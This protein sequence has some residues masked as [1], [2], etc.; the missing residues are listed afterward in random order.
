[1]KIKVCGIRTKSNLTFL[2]HE[3]ADFVGFIFYS[4]SSRNFPD[5]DLKPGD[6]IAYNKQK[7]GVFVDESIE[8]IENTVKTYALDYIQLHGNESP[9]YCK[10]LKKKGYKLFKAF[11]VMNELPDDLK[12]YE[13]YVDYFLFDT[14]GQY[15]GGNGVQFDWSLLEQYGLSNPFILS[16]GIGLDDIASLKELKHPKLFAVDVNS[17]FEVAP[18]YKNEEELKEFIKELKE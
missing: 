10:T 1:M 5:G 3:A 7:V 13:A 4:K 2:T 8:A 16:G 18:G 9:A 14:K 11:S 6:L 17:R 15:H 12:D